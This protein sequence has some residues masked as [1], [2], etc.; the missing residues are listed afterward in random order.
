MPNTAVALA[1][2]GTAL[3]S[4]LKDTSTFN[5]LVG[6]RVYNA[7]APPTASPPYAVFFFIDTVPMLTFDADGYECRV[8]ITMI[9]NKAGGP[10]AM[11]TLA[12]ALRSRLTDTD[13]TVTNH[14]QMAALIDIERGPFRDDERWR[15]DF[16]VM[17]R[18]FRT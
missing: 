7:I 15:Y 10:G 9:G 6:G 1:D 8:Q 5:T 2:V 12:D 11:F 14:D 17:L 18:G 4:H 3:M 13:W 16:D